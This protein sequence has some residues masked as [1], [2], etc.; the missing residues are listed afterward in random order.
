LCTYITV[1]LVALSLVPLLLLCVLNPASAIV[2]ARRGDNAYVLER[3]C[4]DIPSSV[5]P[6][7]RPARRALANPAVETDVYPLIAPEC[8]DHGDGD[9]RSG[10][11]WPME[12][13]LVNSK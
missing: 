11:E 12:R 8:L 5:F 4:V 7:F 10:K 1:N 2:V 6:K 9:V 3:L 13:A